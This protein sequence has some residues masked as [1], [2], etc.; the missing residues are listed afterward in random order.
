MARLQASSEQTSAA[1][2]EIIQAAAELF[3]DLGYTATSIDAIAEKL[4][5]T[6]GRVYHYFDS[7][8][9]IFFAIQ[10]T[11]M[12]RLAATVEPI[13]RSGE[14]A[15]MRLCKM[16]DAHLSRLLGDL[17]IQK[18]AVQGLERYLFEASGYRYV[19]TLRDI[20]KLRDDYE[21]LFAE[22]IDEGSRKGVFVDLPP[23][24]LTKPFF[25]TLNW[26]TVWY[27]PRKLQDPQSISVIRE[28]LV[29]FAMRG[30]RR[31]GADGNGDKSE[32]ALFE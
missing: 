1:K 25:G 6:K 9:E 26:V 16:A 11:A 23:R 18:V 15:E 19:H 31:G 5:A 2:D 14:T 29:S 8:A 10:R 3:M 20:N 4:G 13:A 17:A 30:I 7:K 32:C 27:R 28:A 24:L 21:E 22:V 12:E